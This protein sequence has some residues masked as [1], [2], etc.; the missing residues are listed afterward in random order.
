M[1]G[2]RHPSGY[3][4]R[5]PPVWRPEIVTCEVTDDRRDVRRGGGGRSDPAAAHVLRRR[6]RRAHRA[7][8]RDADNWVA[9]TAN[10]IVDDCGLGAG[11]RAAVGLPPHWQTAAVLLGC[12][13]AGLAV[14]RP[15][16]DAGRCRV[17]ARR[18]TPT[19]EWPAAERYALGS[20]SA[21][22]AAARRARTGTST[23]PPRYARTA[24]TSIRTAPVDAGRCRRG[25][26]DRSDTAS[27]RDAAADARDRHSACAGGRVLIDADAHPDPVDWLLAPLAAG[28]SIVLCRNTGRDEASAP[29]GRRATRAVLTQTV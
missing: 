8:R 14:D 4:Q 3:D 23:S 10:M 2:N 22:A 5:V 28:A 26:A 19:H 13:T 17:R 9:K 16:P 11:N 18:P 24:T 7:V 25:P 27:C 20:A 12:W 21:G 6:D 1:R 15:A 29:G